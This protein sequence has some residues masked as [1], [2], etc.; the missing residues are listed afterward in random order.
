VRYSFVYNCQLFRY[1]MIYLKHYSIFSLELAIYPVQ[2][3]KQSRFTLALTLKYR[4]GFH[5]VSQDH[6]LCGGKLIYS[7]EYFTILSQE[8]VY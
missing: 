4:V 7:T 8:C 6:Q 1:M 5:S 3:K 2:F